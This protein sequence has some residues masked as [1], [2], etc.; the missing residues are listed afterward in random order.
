MKEI[1][2]KQIEK[3]EREGFGY[4]NLEKLDLTEEES[5]KEFEE[6]H[7]RYKNMVK[8]ILEYYDKATNNDFILYIEFLRL[9][10]LMQV[11]SGKDNFVLKIPRDKIKFIP[12]P[13]SIT[14]ARRV[15]N[16][17]GIGLPTNINV[18]KRRLKR[19]KAIR[20]YFIKNE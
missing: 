16:S 10:G 13:E 12:S 8:E 4:R 6:E 18:F 2:N 3:V 1:V 15:L 20:Q 17:K 7:K 14:R 9:L 19:Q 5:I 11:T